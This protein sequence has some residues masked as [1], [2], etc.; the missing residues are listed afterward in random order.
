MITGCEH[1]DGQHCYNCRLHICSQRDDCCVSCAQD[2]EEGYPDVP[3]ETE[4]PD[5]RFAMS[6]CRHVTIAKKYAAMIMLRSGATAGD[7]K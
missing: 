2:E 6:C 7:K 4:L 5:G 3:M 1:G